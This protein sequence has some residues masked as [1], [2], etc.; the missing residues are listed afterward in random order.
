M[1]VQGV[2]PHLLS[3]RLRGEGGALAPKGGGPAGP[4]GCVEG[5]C[6]KGRGKGSEGSKGK[7]SPPLAAMSIYAVE[8]LHR[9]SKSAEVGLRRTMVSIIDMLTLVH[10]LPLR[11]TSPRWEACHL[12]LRSLCSPTNQVPLPPQGETRNL[13][14]PSFCRLTV[15]GG[16]GSLRSP[17]PSTTS[18]SPHPRMRQCYCVKASTEKELSF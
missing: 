13:E 8:V 11:G 9:T 15:V 17:P 16:M 12:I 14:G 1:R 7:V 6:F 2:P 4:A 3:H 5:L 10:P 18:W